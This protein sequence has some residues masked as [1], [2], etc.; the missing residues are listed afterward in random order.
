MD[1]LQ[2]LH[3]W[4]SGVAMLP[5]ARPACSTSMVGV[6]VSLVLVGVWVSLCCSTGDT[7][8]EVFRDMFI[9]VLLDVFDKKD[10]TQFHN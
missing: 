2:A 8:R 10:N 1:F 5:A 7:L 3:F 6:G 9:C 4:A